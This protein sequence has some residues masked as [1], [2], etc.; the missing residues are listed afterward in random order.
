MASASPTAAA[1]RRR[2]RRPCATA[3]AERLRPRASMIALIPVGVA[4]ITGMPSSAARSRAWARC[5]GGPQ[6]PNQASFDG[7]KM[8]LGRL[9]AIDHFAGEDDFVAELESDPAPQRQA[10][11]P[12]PRSR[13]EVGIA[14]REPRQSD[15]GQ[16]RAHRQIF[17]EGHQD[18][19][20]RSGRRP[21]RPGR[22]RRC[23]SRRHRRAGRRMSAG[24]CRR[25]ADNRRVRARRWRAR[26]RTGRGL[27]RRRGGHLRSGSVT[28]A[29]GQNNSLI[30]A[31][32]LRDDDNAARRRAATSS[33]PGVHLSCWPMLGWTMRMGLVTVVS[34]GTFDEGSSHSR[35]S[36][37]GSAPTAASGGKIRAR[38]RRRGAPPGSKARRFR[39][40]RSM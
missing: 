40:A 19:P 31:S 25:S 18:A 13:R 35:P 32:A 14:R 4:R 10:D 38:L 34:S 39:R 11:R 30:P 29:S 37:R 9:L 1:A 12:R 5:C 36:R 6:R 26:V 2:S 28:A 20:C 21:C 17:P 16:Q 8:T 22:A 7:L 3:A 27:E 15:R 33:N 24:R 23:C